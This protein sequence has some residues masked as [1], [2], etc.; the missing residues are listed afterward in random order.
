MK[1]VTNYLKNVTKSM[2][3]ATSDVVSKDLMPNISEF[4]ETN[5]DFINAAYKTFRHPGAALKGNTD[6]IAESKIFQAIDYGIKNTIDD[7]KSGKWYNKERDDQDSLKL[8]GL[9]GDFDDLS[10]FGIDDDWE[11]QIKKKSSTTHKDETTTGEMKIVESVEGTTAASTSA[12]INAMVATTDISMKNSRINTGILYDQNE[13]LFGGLNNRVSAL[14]ATTEAIFKMTSAS[15]ENLDKNTSKFFTDSLKLANERNAI[16]KEMLEMNRNTYKSALDR[17]KEEKENRKK[18]K[19]SWGDIQSD[20]VI[21]FE[22]YANLIKQNIKNQISSIGIPQ[23][24]EDS[25]MLAAMFTSPLKGL[26]TGLINNIIPASVK[27]ASKELNKTIGSVFG[28]TMSRLINAGEDENGGILKILSKFLG[29]NNTVREGLDTNRY[30]KGAV[31]FDGLTRKSIIEVIPT[32]LRRIDAAISG[33]EE[34]IY[35]FREG[36]WTT[37]TRL[38]EN[39]R[40]IKKS[41]INSATSELLK[42]MKPGIDS[43][44][45]GMDTST[46]YEFDK[47]IDQFMEYLYK[48]NGDFNGKKSAKAN[49]ISLQDGSE[50]VKYYD[51][52]REIYENMDYDNNKNRNTK[53]STKLNL[54]RRIH[55]AKASQ[56]RTYRD[57]ELDPSNPLIILQS[58][59]DFNKHGK[60]LYEDKGGNRQITGFKS[61]NILLD[62]RDVYKKNIFD[63]LAN[64]TK[65]IQYIR[66]YGVAKSINNARP[67]SRT[68][69]T[70]NAL[71]GVPLNWGYGNENVSESGLR[72]NLD[73]DFFRMDNSSIERTRRDVE[74]RKNTLNKIE[75]AIKKGEAVDFRHFEKN[76]KAYLDAMREL[77]RKQS[78]ERNEKD[79]KVLSEATPILSFLEENVFQSNKKK[80]SS[81]EDDD[82]NKEDTDAKSTKD[83]DKDDLD[84]DDKEPSKLKGIFDKIKSGNKYLGGI[85]GTP[86]EIFTNILYSADRAIYDM[87][88]KV[89]LKDDDDDKDENNNGDKPKGFIEFI[90]KKAASKFNDIVELAKTDIIEPLKERLGVGEDWSDRFKNVFKSVGKT[91]GEEF[92]KANKDVYSSALGFIKDQVGLGDNDSVLKTRRSNNRKDI[93]NDIDYIKGVKDL[94]DD[95]LIRILTKYNIPFSEY[96]N[97]T[98][99]K[100]DVLPK[101]IQDLVKNSNGMSEFSS[102]EEVQ[103]YNE[104]LKGSDNPIK[105]IEKFAKKLGYEVSG[106]NDQEIMDNFMNHINTLGRYAELAKA[107]NIKVDPGNIQDI[108][109]GYNDKYKKSDYYNFINQYRK[110]RKDDYLL[111]NY[112]DDKNSNVLVNNYIQS[113]KTMPTNEAEKIRK[114]ILESN[115]RTA[116]QKAIAR[117]E[118]RESSGPLSRNQKMRKLA[119]LNGRFTAEDIINLINKETNLTEADYDKFSVSRTDKDGNTTKSYKKYKLLDL[120]LKNKGFSGYAT[121]TFGRPVNGLSM[122]S[123]NETVFDDEGTHTVE[124]TGL[125]NL[126]NA[127]VLN[128]VDSSILQGKKPQSTIEDDLKKETNLKNKILNDID[129]IDGGITLNAKGNIN[130]ESGD[131][132]VDD[133]IE[134]AKNN[135]PEAAAGGLAGAIISQLLGTIGGPL[136]GAAVGASA[137]IIHSSLSLK[138]AIFGKVGDDGKRTGGI[139]SKKVIDTASKYL[140]DTIKFGLAGILPGLVTPLGPLGGLLVGGTIGFLKNYGS[141]QEKYFGENSKI[142]LSKENQDIIKEYLPGAAKGAAVSTITSTIFGGP[143]GLLGNAALGAAVGMVATNEEFKEALLGREINGERY[144]G[145]VGTLKRSL[146]P[147][148]KSLVEIKD[149]ILETIDKGILDPLNRFVNPFI[150]SIPQVLGFIPRKILEH[151]DDLFGNTIGTIVKDKIIDPISKLTSKLVKPIVTAPL[152][153]ITLPFR[154]L[155]ATGDFM[156]AIHLKNRTSSKTADERLQERSQVGGRID[157]FMDKHGILRNT[158]GRVINADNYRKLIGINEDDAF[159]QLMAG[160]TDN[161]VGIA[162]NIR[163]NIDTIINTE[164]SLFAGKEKHKQSIRDTLESYDFGNGIRLTNADKKLIYKALYSGNIDYAKQI[165]SS[166]RLAGANRTLTEKEI[167]NLLYSENAN[168]ETLNSLMSKY[169]NAHD[170]YNAYKD[171]S[172]EQKDEQ[173]ENAKKILSEFGINKFDRTTLRRYQKQMDI[174][175]NRV[176]S[177]SDE[178]VDK[179]KETESTKQLENL[180]SNVSIIIEYLKDIAFLRTE[181][182]K[183]RR[184]ERDVRSVQA[185]DKIKE[186]MSNRKNQARQAA[187]ATGINFDDLSEDV[188]DSMTSR[189]M[190]DD[191]IRGRMQR[192]VDNINEYITGQ[193]TDRNTVIDNMTRNNMSAQE[194]NSFNDLSESTF[195]RVNWIRDRFNITT[196]AIYMITQLSMVEYKQVKR[197]LGYNY[198]AHFLKNRDL[199][200]KDIKFLKSLTAG[201]MNTFLS[202]AKTLQKYKQTSREYPTL[203]SILTVNGSTLAGLK[204]QYELGRLFSSNEIQERQRRDQRV[205]EILN[206]DRDNEEPI[207]QNGIGTFVLSGIRSLFSRKKKQNTGI[208]DKLAAVNQLINRN[209]EELA[210]QKNNT[211]TGMIKPEGKEDGVAQDPTTGEFYKTKLQS[212]GSIVPDTAD[213][214]TKKVM[215]ILKIKNTAKEKLQAAQLKSSELITKMFDTAKEAG[216]KGGKLSW[217]QM[218]LY[219]TLLAK[220]GILTKLFDGIVKPVWTKLIH[221]WI[222]NKVIPWVNN[223]AVPWIENVAIPKIS[224][225]IGKSVITAAKFVVTSL[226]S[227]ISNA[228]LGAGDALTHNKFGAGTIKTSDISDLDDDELTE[229]MDENGNK[230]TAGQLRS[231]KYKNVYNDKGEKGK[232]VDDEGNHSFKDSSLKGASYISNILPMA[233]KSFVTGLMDG[234]KKTIASTALKGADDLGNKLLKSKKLGRTVAGGA[235]KV[236]TAPSTIAHDLGGMLGNKLN[237]KAIRNTVS[238]ELESMPENTAKQIRAKQTKMY[239]GM[240]KELD[241]NFTNYTSKNTEKVVAKSS[242]ALN[243]LKKFLDKLFKNNTILSKFSK[244]AESCGK[245]LS[246]TKLS[247]WIST[248]KD[249]IYKFIKEKVEKQAEKEGSNSIMEF[250][251]GS[252]PISKAVMAGID[253]VSGFDKAESI[254]GISASDTDLAAKICAGLS[255]AV[256]GAFIVLSLFTNSLARFI[257]NLPFFKTNLKEKQKKAQEEYE[258]YRK[259]GGGDASL[260]EYLENHY[261]Y[262]GKIR[263]TVVKG[264]KTVG[265]T[266]KNAAKK[267]ADFVSDIPSNIASGAK[268]FID[269]IKTTGSTLKKV[270]PLKIITDLSSYATKGEYDKF[271][272]YKANGKDANAIIQQALISQTQQFL[273]PVASITKGL[274]GIKNNI[275]KVIND[276]TS[277]PKEASELWDL[278]TDG[279][280]TKAFAY[281]SKKTGV[282]GIIG[283]VVLSVEKLITSPVSLVFKFFKSVQDWVKNIGSWFKDKFSTVKDFFS[284]PVETIQNLLNNGSNSDG[285]DATVD[286]NQAMSERQKEEYSKPNEKGSNESIKKA[287]DLIENT[288]GDTITDTLAKANTDSSGM[289]KYAKQTN[290]S[291]AGIRYNSKNDTEYQTIGD[292]GCGPAA[293]VNAVKSIFGKGTNSEVVNAANFALSRNYKETDGGTKPEFFSDYFN[294]NGLGS[295]ISYDRNQLINNI[296]N[297]QPTVLMGKDPSGVNSSNPFGEQSHYVTVTGTD[298]MGNA[299]V[300]DPESRYDDQL[301]NID[302]LMSK[303]SLGVS[304]Y[305]KGKTK[306]SLDEVSTDS[307]SS[308]NKEDSSETTENTTST[309]DSTGSLLSWAD[310]INSTKAGQALSLLLTSNYTSSSSTSSDGNYSGDGSNKGDTWAFF[311]NKGFSDA[312]TAGIMGNLEQESGIDP[313]AIQGNGKG[314]AAGIAQWE[315]YNTK[316]ARWKQLSEFAK[317]KGTKWTDLTT[318]LEF[319]LAE[320]EGT[321]GDSYTGKLMSKKGGIKKLKEAT[322]YKKAALLFEQVF[323]RAGK[324]MM[325]KRYKYAKNILDKYSGTGKA[326]DDSSSSSESESKTTKGG[327]KSGKGKFGLGKFFGRAKSKSSTDADK[328]GETVLEDGASTSDVFPKYQLTDAQ[329]KGIANIVAHEQGSAAGRLAEA[330]L[331]A[332]RTDIKGGKKSASD[333]VKTVTGGWFADGKSRYNNPGNVPQQAIDAVKTVIVNGK[334]TIPRYVDEHDYMGD[335]SS[336]TTNGKS[337]SKK[338][339]SQYQ[340]DLTVIKNKMG[341]TYTFYEFPDANSDP[342]GYTN[343]SYKKKWG[344]IHYDGDKLTGSL[345]DGSTESSTNATSTASSFIDTLSSI[346]NNSN[347]GKSLAILAN[348]STTSSDETTDSSGYTGGSAVGGSAGKLIDVAANEIGY[349]E[350]ASNSNLDNKTANSGSA[351]YT[352]YGKWY[353]MN[354]VPWCAE[355]VSWSANQAGIPTDV[356]PKYAATKSGYQW[357]KDKHQTVS[358][359]N[360]KAGDIVFFTNS[361]QGIHHTGIVEDV[362]NGEIHTIEGNSSDVVKRRTYKTSESGILVGRPKYSSEGSATTTDSSKFAEASGQANYSDTRGGNKNKPMSKYGQFRDSLRGS[363]NKYGMGKVH[364]IAN[365]DAYGRIDYTEY[366]PDMIDIS[367]ASNAKS[368]SSYGKG[369]SQSVNYTDLIKVVIS[370]LSV[371]ADNTDKLNTIVTILNDKLGVN[372]TQD[373]VSKVNKESLKSKL[374]GALNNNNTSTMNKTYRDTID[375]STIQNIINTMNS[376]ASE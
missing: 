21:D 205:N 295:Q 138:D 78:T 115:D 98:D 125:Y 43:Y 371:I 34:K 247:S 79:I 181:E 330:S 55:D 118:A 210:P 202:N 197:L 24:N 162:E 274:I 5:K 137:S 251:A 200:D 250:L 269:N 303:S 60:M 76:P 286:P 174:D 27:M 204:T 301:Y 136:V 230:L 278:A 172:K 28:L 233:G 373:D 19:L 68:N 232:L 315:N 272:S 166:S 361:S 224:S 14:T 338:S 356:I 183:S 25:N 372:I 282:A 349:H 317:S 341:S 207:Q 366:D 145:F 281:T 266:V 212:D 148:T 220:S 77:V 334:R 109:K 241:Q 48:K 184:E 69:S 71:F 375:K 102:R 70:P 44:K 160:I 163:D 229:M 268:S 323:E 50:F 122:L 305:G 277:I 369:K 225:L 146:E 99:A 291:I 252:N 288:T 83:T 66:E 32:Y 348:T 30:E 165:L 161:N 261:S 158:V 2:A 7:L 61:N 358:A 370:T 239:E 287:N 1:G 322:D 289:G 327:S 193:Q 111:D 187:E 23:F 175:I 189:G 195:R 213:N 38:K 221:P 203:D 242:K 279:E 164:D 215:N 178:S 112:I 95:G 190:N 67:N 173:I 3:F 217:L 376:L 336:V 231:G 13:R 374:K 307:K 143:F 152:K 180:N 124:K 357:F 135:I 26:A 47:A 86:A 339:K 155:G 121:G 140:P 103:L 248:V 134:A 176:K 280:V 290:P 294:Q 314:P 41:S 319:L 171:M 244:F 299:I 256:C 11:D 246:G 20:G 297:G 228:I 119:G 222:N 227:I 123:K 97:I 17:E 127:Q 129:N 298:G 117:K 324:P 58:G 211:P 331:I 40:S 350:K 236:L 259:K 313:K 132:N 342:F 267:G 91:I 240:F 192:R 85:I 12:T 318:Q 265:K 296:N 194:L 206:Q 316:S 169:A 249:N 276:I 82:K 142:K 104:Y 151:F 245:K 329:L 237:K 235:V 39:F 185:D 353:G 147:L 116:L 65:E 87:F 113:L 340:K 311:K 321:N 345:G 209:T 45:K 64:L 96:Y 365:K 46:K 198:V 344:D 260:E 182:L 243:V 354:G 302:E 33:T 333:L 346:M 208:T 364:K 218:L 285:Q 196:K 326:V 6:S 126:R 283:N 54:A 312:G 9:G 88:F 131:I 144:G 223:T 42:E 238:K 214:Q 226:P 304:A 219:G 199:T 325:D 310:A 170:K 275:G 62:T 150:K 234:N 201:D 105:E 351:N 368:K 255:N 75:E 106:S 167:D 320:L 128:S 264:V 263:S 308:D 120:Y 168:G 360:S 177:E 300:Q 108:V 80:S 179:S 284:N 29:F 74:E 94:R 81:K 154:A 343:K 90:T 4:T 22:N 37:H 110:S 59:I 92:V 57:I 359:A 130:I 367:S 10:E 273:S 133:V 15:M 153:A 347:V 16:L 188:V 36:K 84:D 309:G 156:N 149:S 52:I 363:K 270:N 332:N 63:Y 51:I 362:S 191:T 159:D 72:I 257:Y 292:S 306:S 253:F 35:D 93:L 352:K 114:Y 107:N 254:L 8:S 186:M 293:A 355:F 49:K 328:K 262:S 56:E 100:S 258:N 337:I 271:T 73:N 101:L 89:E 335:I 157:K 216:S 141:F 139:V 31:P 53:Y 18:K